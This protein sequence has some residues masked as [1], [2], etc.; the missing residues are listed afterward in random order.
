MRP[1]RSFGV[2]T[3]RDCFNESRFDRLLKSAFFEGPVAVDSLLELMMDRE[4][5]RDKEVDL[6]GA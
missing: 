6:Q 5:K 2:P 3:V 1:T 4:F